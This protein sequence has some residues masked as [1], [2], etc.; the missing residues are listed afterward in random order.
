MGNAGPNLITGNVL[1]TKGTLA[2]AK[3]EIA[4][5]GTIFTNNLGA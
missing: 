5:A 2:V 1:I 3:T 4:G